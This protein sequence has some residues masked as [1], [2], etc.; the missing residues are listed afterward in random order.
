MPLVT[1]G[2]VAA[3]IIFALGGTDAGGGQYLV[4]G[5]QAEMVLAL[6]GVGDDTPPTD[7][8]ILRED[9]TP[10]LREDGTEFMRE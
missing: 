6:G 3:A 10:L 7:D 8:F 9:D 1:P 2:R 4:G 5:A